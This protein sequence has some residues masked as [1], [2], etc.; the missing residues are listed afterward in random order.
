MKSGPTTT[1][2]QEV[3]SQPNP[4]DVLWVVTRARTR[5]GKPPLRIEPFAWIYPLTSAIPCGVQ[6]ASESRTFMLRECYTDIRAA[7]AAVA[8]IADR[9]LDIAQQAFT[10]TKG[11][12]NA[13]VFASLNY[14]G[15]SASPQSPTPV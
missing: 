11:K 3:L 2:S 5:A 10:R 9:E 8:K 12:L 13:A 14:A 1:L 7:T 15:D 4:P 6:L